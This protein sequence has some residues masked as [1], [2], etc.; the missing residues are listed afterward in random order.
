MHDDSSN[1]YE[2]I[3]HKKSP[4]REK[5]QDLV[6]LVILKK[7]EV[8]TEEDIVKI[9]LEIIKNH[10]KDIKEKELERMKLEVEQIVKETFQSFVTCTNNI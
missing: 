7:Y 6:T 4:K 1:M 3:T 8:C 5:L 10:K 2:D 9:V